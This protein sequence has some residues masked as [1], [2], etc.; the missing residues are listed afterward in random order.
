MSY[1][2]ASSE[3]QGPARRIGPIPLAGHARVAGVEI[4]WGKGAVSRDERS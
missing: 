3:E 4:G 1:I 2:L